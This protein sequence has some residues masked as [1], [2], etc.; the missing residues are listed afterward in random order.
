MFT[1]DRLKQ[2]VHRAKYASS[3]YEPEIA[4]VER[5]GFEIHSYLNTDFEMKKR[6]MMLHEQALESAGVLMRTDFKQNFFN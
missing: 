5:R 3:F 1:I 4:E 6:R 2:K